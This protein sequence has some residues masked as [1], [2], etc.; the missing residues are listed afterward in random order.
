VA[1]K[2]V[3]SPG[4]QDGLYYAEMRYATNTFF[5]LAPVGPLVTNVDSPNT[6]LAFNPRTAQ[7]AIVYRSEFGQIHYIERSAG[8]AWTTAVIDLSGDNTAW[9]TLAFSPTTGRRAVAYHK[10]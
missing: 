3:V 4:A 5:W 10:A 6:S 7:P 9:T 8:G 2:G 1:Y